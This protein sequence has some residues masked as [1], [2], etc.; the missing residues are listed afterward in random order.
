MVPA[1]HALGHVAAVRGPAAGPLLAAREVQVIPPLPV[2][3]RSAFTTI[4]DLA[5]GRVLED[6]FGMQGGERRVHV[7][8]VPGLDVIEQQLLKRRCH[9]GSLGWIGD[10]DRATCMV[11]WIEPFRRSFVMPIA[12]EKTLQATHGLV[13]PDRPPGVL[14]Q[15]W[16]FAA[17]RDGI[18]SGR[19]PAGLRLPASRTLAAQYGISRGTVSTVYEQLAAE[20]YVGAVAALDR[21]ALGPDHRDQIIEGLGA[22][23]GTRELQRQRQ[24]VLL[25]VG[26]GAGQPEALHGWLGRHRRLAAPRSVMHCCGVAPNEAQLVGIAHNVDAAD[27]AAAVE[28]ES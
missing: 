22:D 27:Q 3:A 16:L 1:V 24:I 25:L 6:T 18:V 8:R 14:L 28:L 26:K 19:L 23:Q 5:G 2:V 10:P 12:R 20:N 4:E 21:L 17:L 7:V 9:E 13:F 15:A 11:Q